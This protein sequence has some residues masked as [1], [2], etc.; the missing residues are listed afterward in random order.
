M[1]KIPIVPADPVE[2]AQMP[3]EGVDVPDNYISAHKR[4]KM[5]R[6]YPENE[7]LAKQKASEAIHAAEGVDG[8]T[9]DAAAEAAQRG[10]TA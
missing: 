10:R 4:R 3:I 5:A 6:D 8:G 7:G 9:L 1:E 2:A